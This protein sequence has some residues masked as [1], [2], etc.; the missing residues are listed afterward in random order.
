MAQTISYRK[1]MA[2]ASS[3]FN[4]KFKLLFGDRIVRGFTAVPTGMRIS[5]NVDPDFGDSV[6]IYNGVAIHESEN[7][8][9]IVTVD[10]A[11]S[12]YARY[13]VLYVTYDHEEQ[14]PVATYGLVKGVAVANPV[15]P[16][17]PANSF[18]IATI[19]VPPNVVSIQSGNI[20]QT[21]EGIGGGI[22]DPIEVLQALLEVDGAGSGLDADLFR[23]NSPS[24][25]A[26]ATH[27]HA[28]ANIT[29][30]QS[31]LNTL[32]TSLQSKLDSSSYT[33]QDVLTKIKSVD[34][35]DSGL[36]A[37][38]FQGLLP[39]NFVRKYTSRTAGQFYT[40]TT[41]P[42]STNRINYD[43]YF[44]AT[45]CFNPAY[46]DYAEF[47]PRGEETVE[48]D[49]I[50]LNPETGSYRKSRKKK[51]RLVRGV[52]SENYG[53]IIGGDGLE[54]VYERFIPIGLAGIVPVKII[55]KACPGQY[56]VASGIP[57]VGMAVKFPIRGATLGQI[58]QYKNT[59]DIGLV[60]MFIKIM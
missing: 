30:L 42:T 16:A 15:K 51:S 34:G 29:N 39:T 43:G 21:I 49:I 2:M 3:L 50:E 41:N 13:D 1:R 57:G 9:N 20:E 48:G 58:E 23:G 40:G 10:S 5:L 53:H 18:E 8:T 12:T 38:R 6:L 24:A 17:I 47:F 25:F 27:N 22:R 46:Y 7:L 59:K 11:H 44:Y 19:T 52:H 28:I 26:T 36:D 37:D 31:T 45:R 60:K 32:N 56:V 4:E 35:E 33:A 54:N 55:G 14:E